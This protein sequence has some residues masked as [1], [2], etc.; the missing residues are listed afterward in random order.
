MQVLVLDLVWHHRGA[1][2]SIAFALSV[3]TAPGGPL[4]NIG[5]DNILNANYGGSGQDELLPSQDFQT[6]W[7]KFI[8]QVE[9]EDDSDAEVDAEDVKKAAEAFIKAGYRK[10]RRAEGIELSAIG[11]DNL[12]PSQKLPVKRSVTVL[13]TVHQMRSQIQRTTCDAKTTCC[14]RHKNQQ[15]VKSFYL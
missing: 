4:G 15:I 10:P 14:F 9:I 13:E 7:I 5:L 6:N 3:M 1:W 2:N 11:T 8:T 12:T